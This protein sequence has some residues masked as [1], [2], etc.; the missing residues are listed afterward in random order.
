MIATRKPS[1]IPPVTPAAPVVGM[2]RPPTQKNPYGGNMTPE[3]AAALGKT[4]GVNS[5]R[6]ADRARR[7]GGSVIGMGNPPTHRI[8]S[9]PGALTGA[10][11]PNGVQPP[12][13]AS[14]VGNLDYSN[15]QALIESE[16]ATNRFDQSNPYGEQ[17]VTYDPATG[18][19][20]IA[21]KLS[22]PQQQILDAAQSNEVGTQNAYGSQLQTVNSA[23]KQPIDYSGLQGVDMQN[24]ATRQRVEQSIMQRQRSQLDPVFSEQQQNLV[25]DFR[26]RGIE[27][28]SPQWGDQQGR[29]A[30]SQNRAYTDAANQAVMS[31]GQEADRMFRSQMDLR[32][33][34]GNEML[35]KRSVPM[36]ELSNFAQLKQGVTN[37][38]FQSTQPVD[39]SGLGMGFAQLDAQKAAQGAGF[40]QDRALMEANQKFQASQAAKDRAN[41]QAMAQISKRAG[42]GGGSGE[43][44]TYAERKAIDLQFAEQAAALDAKFRPKPQ[45]PWA[46]VANTVLAAGGQYLGSRLF[47]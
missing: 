29:L 26:A 46:G 19:S 36:S 43:N 18:R 28:A 22:A 6:I 38:A 42:G 32:A 41:Q 30:D 11:T 14:P 25:R 20:K 31:G 40:A 13:A 45:S 12:Q 15:P 8:R 35:S 39:V 37:P 44:L 34:Q 1:R 7:A 21:T 27:Y 2:S 16:L 47:Q 5:A 23:V 33:Q 24:D 4:T 3:Q 9:L 17:N 10:L